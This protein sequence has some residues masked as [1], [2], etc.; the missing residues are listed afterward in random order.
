MKYSIDQ[1]VVIYDT[2]LK[3]KSWRNCRKFHG[4]CCESEDLPKQVS[5]NGISVRQ[6]ENL[7]KTCTDVRND[8]TGVRL[9]ASPKKSLLVLALQ[10]GTLRSRSTVYV[11]TKLVSYDP[12][13]R[14]L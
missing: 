2:V 7:G 1:R 11:A 10:R 9:E 12:T 6:K 5:C 8:N 14:Q 4:Q 13:K 3:R